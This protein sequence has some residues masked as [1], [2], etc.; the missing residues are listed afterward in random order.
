MTIFLSGCKTIGT[1][2]KIIIR[3][4]DPY[5]DE[6]FNIPEG[7]SLPPDHYEFKPFSVVGDFAS[8]KTRITKEYLADRAYQ[9]WKDTGIDFFDAKDMYGLIEG[10]AKS[11]NPVHFALLD[12]QVF[13]MDS[14]NPMGNKFITQIYYTI[15]HKLQ[16]KAKKSGGNLGGLVICAILVQ[17]FNALDRRLRKNAM[18]TIFKDWDEFGCKYYNIDQEIQDELLEWK[19]GSG[20]LTDYNA[21]KHA[22]VV[23]I[24][25]EGCIIY[26]DSPKNK[27]LPFEFE[28]VTGISVYKEQKKEFIDY[29][30]K[31][32]FEENTRSD[33]EAELY[34]YSEKMQ[35]DG[36]ELYV[37]PSDF[38]E[39][40]IRAKRNYK[41]QN[42]Y[43]EKEIVQKNQT[44]GWI[45][46][47]ILALHDTVGLTFKAIENKF[48]IPHSTAHDWYKQEKENLSKIINKEVIQENIIEV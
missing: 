38:R 6:R 9:L 31:F 1:S 5:I 20:S 8:G 29:I 35:S 45:K 36:Y 17:D 23:D 11:K 3:N 15:R 42:Q 24:K 30:S 43:I 26:Y 13:Y 47:Q 39:I 28:T 37:K 46:Q 34:E 27:R 41:N 40:Y 18:F 2:G 4:I 10:V 33:L 16:E 7:Q 14:R 25:R 32:D 44:D 19:I 12:D 21:R 48:R 22:F